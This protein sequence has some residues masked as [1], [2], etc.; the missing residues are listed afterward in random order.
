MPRTKKKKPPEKTQSDTDKK[1]SEN[2]ESDNKE[3]NQVRELNTAGASNLT[4]NQDN[5]LNNNISQNDTNNTNNSLSSTCSFNLSPQITPQQSITDLNINPTLIL[6]NTTTTTTTTVTTVS[7]FANTTTVH[8]TPQVRTRLSPTH[9]FFAADFQT[10]GNDSDDSSILTD[11]STQSIINNN[12]NTL[13]QRRRY[14]R[15][16]TLLMISNPE[17]QASTIQALEQIARTPEPEPVPSPTLE[18]PTINIQPLSNPI[19]LEVPTEKNKQLANQK[20]IIKGQKAKSSTPKSNPPSPPVPSHQSPI[21]TNVQ[22]PPIPSTSTGA[23]TTHPTQQTS[24]RP[25][26][27]TSLPPPIHIYT[28]DHKQIMQLINNNANDRPDYKYNNSSLICYPKGP[29]DHNKII[30]VL[31]TNQTEFYSYNINT[32]RPLKVVVKYI[33]LDVTNQD[34]EEDLRLKNLPILYVARLMTPRGGRRT[35]TNILILTIPKQS[36]DDYYKL[37]ELC[38]YR[39]SVS[40]Y[41]RQDIPQCHRCQHF[42]HSSAVCNRIS[43]CVRCGETHEGSPC[44]ASECKC[45]NCGGGHP[46][47]Y[48]GCPGYAAAKIRFAPRTE[49][50]K[51]TQQT[52]PTPG[53]RTQ[54]INRQTSTQQQQQPD[55]NYPPLSQETANALST[56]N[57]LDWQRFRARQ[58]A[59]TQQIQQ[60][61]TQGRAGGT[62]EGNPLKE[63]VEYL[64][65]FNLRKILDTLKNLINTLKTTTDPL[66]KIFVILEYATNLF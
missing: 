14:K 23:H 54:P 48:R 64:K 36:A 42:G 62:D 12:N 59:A 35:P 2:T 65:S 24:S 29:R 3:Q 15:K 66:E 31:A 32:Q 13:Y 39:V 40:E 51:R 61:A 20:T 38:Y 7:T 60:A 55:P 27:T 9:T 45:A 37:T 63:I 28:K 56:Q 46:S 47:N 53:Q 57:V 19:Q 18:P 52:L 5:N 6:C 34:I 44:A 4:S 49:Q 41:I 17:T 26:Q 22:T 21:P 11:T 8:S 50:P 30:K 10:R 25:P 16:R 33:P 43:R 1:T 58:R